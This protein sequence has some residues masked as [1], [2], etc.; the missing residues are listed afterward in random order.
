MSLVMSHALDNVV[1]HALTGP[2]RLLGEVRGRAARFDP[3]VAPFAGVDDP[4]DPDAW[5]DLAALVGPGHTTALFAPD[6]VVPD[7]WTERRRIPCF[8][9]IAPQDLGAS[10]LVARDGATRDLVELGSDD[11]PEMLDLIEETKP[12]PFAPRTVDFGGYVGVRDDA[13]RLVA[14]TG[15]R[16]RVDGFTEVSAVCTRPELRGTGLATQLVLAVVDTIHAR[17][18]RAFL[19]VAHDNAS[20][21]RLYLALGFTERIKSDALAVTAPS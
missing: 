21:L 11:V 17:G 5:R 3:D 16:M 8:Q 19:H 20:A 7:G 12:G 9:L 2:R 18:E 13:G 4:A 10:S 6:V 14:M 15:E 1:W